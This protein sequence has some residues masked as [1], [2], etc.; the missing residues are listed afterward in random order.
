MPYW[1]P[2]IDKANYDDSPYSNKVDVW[3]LGMVFAEMLNGTRPRLDIRSER[4]EK[5]P[6]VE[7]VNQGLIELCQKML[8]KDP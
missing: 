8:R 3:S 7:G 4:D 1:A 6:I 2:E 5:L